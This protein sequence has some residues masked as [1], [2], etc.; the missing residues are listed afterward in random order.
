MPLALTAYIQLRLR[1]LYT[2]QTGSTRNELSL[3]TDA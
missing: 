3:G 1:A 2:L